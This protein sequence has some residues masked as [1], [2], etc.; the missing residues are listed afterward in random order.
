M[1]CRVLAI[2]LNTSCLF[3]N[4]L[5]ITPQIIPDEIDVLNMEGLST[6]APPT[7]Q[8]IPR[9]FTQDPGRRAARCGMKDKEDQGDHPKTEGIKNSSLLRM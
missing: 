5:Q 9:I 6:I 8:S 4:D 2:S 1:N 3:L 7:G